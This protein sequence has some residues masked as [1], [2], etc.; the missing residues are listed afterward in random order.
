M[1]ELPIDHQFKIRGHRVE[2]AEVE[3]AVREITGAAV[4]VALPWPPGNAAPQALLVAVEGLDSA[5]DPAQERALLTNLRSRLPEAMLP[6][7]LVALPRLE[8]QVSG[9]VDRAAVAKQVEAML[10][11]PITVADAY[12]DTD[13]GMILEALR[14]V[15]PHLLP[16]PALS[17]LA[18]GLDSLSLVALSALLE[19]H[20]G[21]VL[22]ADSVARLAELPLVE[23]PKLL[24]GGSHI[25]AANAG[26]TA[27]SPR[28]NRV[29]QFI[30]RFPEV[31]SKTDQPMLLA[32]GSS[33]LFRAFDPAVA[34]RVAAAHGHGLRALNVGL[35]A[36]DV[37]S[38]TLICR[39]IR[40]TCQRHGL[41]LPIV[42]YEFDPMMLSVLM[43]ATDLRLTHEHFRR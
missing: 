21:A 4:A 41:R 1:G 38:L 32:V 37:A 23:V 15:A 30:R 13:L 5:K 18:S 28:A 26:L 9:K 25:A 10:A 20:F 19:Q 24:R 40:E 22:D 14:T 35:P 17:L 36:I 7:R 39:F 12:A 34:E 2:A 6:S 31:V 33:G 43:P 29:F 11:R 8:T 3:A 16:D 27:G 42:V